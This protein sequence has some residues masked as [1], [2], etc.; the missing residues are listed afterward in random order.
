MNQAVTTDHSKRQWIDL[1]VHTEACMT[2]PETCGAAGGAVS[3]WMKLVDCPDEFPGGIISSYNYKP[4]AV[5]TGFQMYC[6]ND[7]VR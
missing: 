1:G 7:V 5:T 2:R 4:H 3:F 6:L